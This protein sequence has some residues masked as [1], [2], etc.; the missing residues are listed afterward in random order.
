MRQCAPDDGL[1]LNP[2]SAPNVIAPLAGVSV[3]LG[4]APAAAAQAAVQRAAQT[5]A[6]QAGRFRLVGVMAA[7]GSDGIALIAVDG[8]PAGTFRVGNAVEGDIVLR[9]VSART[10]N[11]GTRDGGETITLEL[12]PAPA[13]VAPPE[14][15]ATTT[16]TVFRPQASLPPLANGS[17]QAQDILRKLGSK[18]PPLLPP[19]PIAPQKPVDGNTAPVD[20][21]RWRP[22][23][24]Q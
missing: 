15:A 6:A 4:Q 17:T 2:K 13:A 24:Q 21:G 8:K 1:A 5:L 7:L 12:A 22:A 23:G 18:H 10:A 11:L 16:T 20:D 3:R 19:T 9:S 14:P